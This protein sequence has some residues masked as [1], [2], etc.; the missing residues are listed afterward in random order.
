MEPY[1]SDFPHAGLFLPETEKLARRGICLPTGTGVNQAQISII[2]QILQ[3]AVENVARI[4][5]KFNS[6]NE[7]LTNLSHIMTI[8]LTKNI[9]YSSDR[10]NV[11]NL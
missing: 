1:R 11:R 9:S 5:D 10:E 2:C 8:A 4:R 3:L 6:P 7:E